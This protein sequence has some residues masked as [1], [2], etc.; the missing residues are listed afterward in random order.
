[1]HTYTVYLHTGWQPKYTKADH[2]SWLLHKMNWGKLYTSLSPWSGCLFP[3][4]KHTPRQV[5]C[6]QEPE[7][8][9]LLFD[10]CSLNAL[11]HAAPGYGIKQPVRCHRDVP[12]QVGIPHGLIHADSMRD[13]KKSAQLP[14][15]LSDSDQQLRLETLQ[16]PLESDGSKMPSFI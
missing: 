15:T 6:R 16:I 4:G 14:P 11:S 10:L 5:V 12:E 13:W 2:E 1:M 3:V 7:G 8:K 9:I